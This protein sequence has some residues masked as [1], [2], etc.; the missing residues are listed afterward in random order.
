[1]QEEETGGDQN[2]AEANQGISDDRDR[3]KSY[4][5]HEWKQNLLK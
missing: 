1:M 5:Q 3:K 4:T 2:Q